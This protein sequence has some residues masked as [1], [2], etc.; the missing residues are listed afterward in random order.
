MVSCVIAII[1]PLIADNSLA[2]A[3]AMRLMCAGP[4]LSSLCTVEFLVR[5]NQF[6]FIEANPR[7]QV[8]HTVTEA[9]YALDLVALQV[10]RPPV[11]NQP[12]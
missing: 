11:R 10:K 9:I 5:D 12:F 2:T 6:W 3:A 7:L 1:Y 8:E 4:P